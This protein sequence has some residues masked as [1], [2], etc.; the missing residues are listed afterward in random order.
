MAVN[1]IQHEYALVPK[2]YTNT[3]IRPITTL[4]PHILRH[5]YA[6]SLYRAGVDVK[7]AQILLGH[8]DIRMTMDLYNHIAAESKEVTE[9]L[10]KFHEC[11]QNAVKVDI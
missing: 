1:H 8:G 9:K 6:T 2:S 11:G 3:K 5:E 10:D 7:T 4:T